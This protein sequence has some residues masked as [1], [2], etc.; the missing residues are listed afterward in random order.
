M[1]KILLTI[2]IAFSLMACNRIEKETRVLVKSNT[3][4]LLVV[5]IPQAS[6]PKCQQVIE[7]GLAIN[8]GIKQSILNLTTKQVSVVYNPAITSAQVIEASLNKLI[9]QMPCK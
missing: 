9:P 3:D 4:S 1:K 6:C 2:T 7:G 8:Q 5:N